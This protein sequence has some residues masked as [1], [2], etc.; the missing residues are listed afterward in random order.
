VLVSASTR[1]VLGDKATVEPV[2]GLQLKGVAEPVTGYV[3][4]TLADEV[5]Q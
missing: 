3:V 4:K 2:Q 5:E 1:A